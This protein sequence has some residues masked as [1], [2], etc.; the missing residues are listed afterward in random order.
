M[1]TS[2]QCAETNR[3]QQMLTHEKISAVNLVFM[4]L[5][6]MSL[7]TTSSVSCLE[8][9]LKTSGGFAVVILILVTLHLSPS[10]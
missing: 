2:Q 1:L 10:H 3:E 8:A 9:D 7:S 6:L 5:R 4:S